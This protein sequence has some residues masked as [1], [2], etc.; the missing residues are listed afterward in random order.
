MVVV[1]T[2]EGISN[3]MTFPTGVKSKETIQPKCQL[4]T[5][6]LRTLSASACGSQA[7]RL[8]RDCVHVRRIFLIDLQ[9]TLV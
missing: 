1:R 9:G 6:V 3:T 7:L 8:A 5:Y 4:Y 2:L